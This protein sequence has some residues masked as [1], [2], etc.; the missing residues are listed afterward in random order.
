MKIRVTNPIVH[1]G[2]EYPRGL[3][4]LSDE[5]AKKF[6][7]FTWAAEKYIEP[8]VEKAKEEASKPGKR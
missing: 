1:D 4:E 6:L 3:H 2:T 7:A 5:L 8:V